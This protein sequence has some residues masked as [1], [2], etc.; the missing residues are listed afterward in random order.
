MSQAVISMRV[1][2]KMFGMLFN[3]TVWAYNIIKGTKVVLVSRIYKNISTGECSAAARVETKLP[4]EELQEE[5][6]KIRF[7]DAP[8]P[9][10]VIIQYEGLDSAGETA[11]ELLSD[12]LTLSSLLSLSRI[13]E[14]SKRLKELGDDDI[15]ITS[16][17]LYVPI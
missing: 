7:D 10:S 11:E 1:S 13:K 5:L 14:Y 9:V 4:L 15:K 12:P 16:E 6:D 8:T 3:R 2:D 17:G